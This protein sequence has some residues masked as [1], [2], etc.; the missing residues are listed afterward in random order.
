ME[1]MDN[2]QDHFGNIYR[3]MKTERIKWKCQKLKTQ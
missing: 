1:K 3:K 2:K